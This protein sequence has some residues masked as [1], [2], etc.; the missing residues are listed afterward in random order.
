MTT[1]HTRR[2]SS[3][4]VF[5]YLFA[6]TTASL[7]AEVL[8]IA[9]FESYSDGDPVIVTNLTGLNDT[10]SGKI[11]AAHDFDVGFQPNANFIS[12]TGQLLLTNGAPSGNSEIQRK[13][14]PSANNVFVISFDME[15]TSSSI[16]MTVSGLNAGGADAG[17]IDFNRNWIGNTNFRMTYVA[18]L[19]GVTVDLPGSLTDL[20]PNQAG[21]FFRRT[22]GTYS[23]PWGISGNPAGPVSVTEMPVGFRLRANQ[24]LPVGGPLMDNFVVSDSADVYDVTT[25]TN[26]LEFPFGTLSIN[27]VPEPGSASLVAIAAAGFALRMRRRD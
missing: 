3:F 27:A 26:I 4:V 9:D 19:S 20:L 18:N 11:G 7:H 22:D 2:G 8:W 1:M 6:L 16:V 5:A 12:N 21:I 17:R 14:L 10:F 24:F 23:E 15:N 25:F 13:N